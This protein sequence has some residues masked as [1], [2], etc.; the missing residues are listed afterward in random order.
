MLESLKLFFARKHYPTHRATTPQELDAIARVVTV[1]RGQVEDLDRAGEHQR[2]VVV[3]VALLVADGLTRPAVAVV[4]LGP[5]Q[6][7]VELAGRRR[8]S[9]VIVVAGG[10]V[11]IA[12]GVVVVGRGGVV[13][14]R[15]SG[16][17][18]VR[19]K[20]LVW[21]KKKAARQEQQAQEDKVSDDGHQ[22]VSRLARR[23]SR[24]RCRWAATP[25]PLLR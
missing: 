11:V 13:V 21:G 4:V 18:V 23:R 7:G 9:R 10:V 1:V 5:G 22:G 19:R 20:G 12:S 2:G 25:V 24:A 3:A 14:V 8:R 6:V 17:V 15:R 16:V